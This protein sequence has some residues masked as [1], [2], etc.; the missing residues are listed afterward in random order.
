ML[1]EKK[2][3][4]G[5]NRIVTLPHSVLLFFFAFCFIIHSLTHSFILSRIRAG[6]PPLYRILVLGGLALFLACPLLHNPHIK[7]YRLLVR[8]GKKEK[9]QKPN[10]L[11]PLTHV[12]APAAI[13]IYTKAASLLLTTI[14]TAASLTTSSPPP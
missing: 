10:G 3:S 9:K 6:S 8:R 12:R 5:R 2:G 4:K 11:L 14:H 7:K 1:S 13:Y